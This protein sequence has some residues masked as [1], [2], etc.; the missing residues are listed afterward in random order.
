MPIALHLSRLRHS[1]DCGVDLGV[2]S[3]LPSIVVNSEGGIVIVV[4]HNSWRFLNHIDVFSSASEAEAAAPAAD[5][6]KD[7]TENNHTEESPSED[8]FD[9]LLAMVI[10][11]AIVVT[12]ILEPRVSLPISRVVNVIVP[13]CATSVVCWTVTIARTSLLVACSE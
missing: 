3:W 4:I 9:S 13:S 8:L 10:W 5:H 2:S 1:I 6:P 12:G 7:G 11:A